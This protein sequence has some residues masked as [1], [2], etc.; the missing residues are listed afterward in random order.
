MTYHLA[1]D[2]NMID[3]QMT[4]VATLK[5]LNQHVLYTF[6][7]SFCLAHLIAQF[8]S[9]YKRGF[10]PYWTIYFVFIGVYII[11]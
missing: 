2:K 8:Q 10:K 9:E 1:I 3:S 11:N 5:K 4:S 6:L 7:N